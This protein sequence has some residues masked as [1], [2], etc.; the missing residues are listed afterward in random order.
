MWEQSVAILNPAEAL[1]EAQESSAK[2]TSAP[3]NADRIRAMSDEE[4]METLYPLTDIEKI[5]PF[6]KGLQECVGMLANDEDIPDEK[7]KACLLKWLQ[8]SAEVEEVT[9]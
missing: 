3:T 9:E 6:C 7:Y 8:Q 5:A 1:K 4:L 2:D